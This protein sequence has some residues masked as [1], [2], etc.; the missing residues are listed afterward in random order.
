MPIYIIAFQTRLLTSLLMSPRNLPRVYLAT[1]IDFQLHYLPY[2]SNISSPTDT[3]SSCVVRMRL[4]PN[5]YLARDYLCTTHCKFS[6]MVYYIS[7]TEQ[8][9]VKLG[10]NLSKFSAENHSWRSICTFQCKRLIRRMLNWF[11]LRT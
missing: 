3:L 11:T 10:Y 9:G 6:V 7:C 2:K 8:G 1:N 5:Q 4:Y